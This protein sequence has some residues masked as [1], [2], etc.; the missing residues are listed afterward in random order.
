M[1]MEHSC[2][3]FSCPAHPNGYTCPCV[4][5]PN[6]VTQGFYVASNRTLTEKEIAEIEA[7]LDSD[8]GVGRY[9]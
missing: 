7:K 4:V 1:M 2:F 8:Y 6:R 3:N 5:C 9:S